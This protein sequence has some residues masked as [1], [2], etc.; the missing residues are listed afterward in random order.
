[1]ATTP[2]PDLRPLVAELSALA[3]LSI[4]SL[5]MAAYPDI[6]R[7]AVLTEIS[8]AAAA[9]ARRAALLGHVDYRSLL[10][11]VTD[12]ADVRAVL[13]RGAWLP[14]MVRPVKA[15]AARVAPVLTTEVLPVAATQLDLFAEGGV[16]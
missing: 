11:Q 12:P 4:R 5:Y 3:V 16:R 14:T 2:A 15:P 1:M 8:G 7:V 10:V 6:V 13:G 9:L